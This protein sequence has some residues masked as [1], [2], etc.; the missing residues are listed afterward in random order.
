MTKRTR[1]ILINELYD[2]ALV[3]AFAGC[4][5]TLYADGHPW[6]CVLAVALGVLR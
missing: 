2:G 6:L 5:A 1:A 3:L 4:A